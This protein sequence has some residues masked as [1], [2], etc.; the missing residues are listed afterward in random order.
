VEAPQ[1]EGTVPAVDA[2]EALES[3][4]NPGKTLVVGDSLGVGT[5]PYLQERLG[6]VDANVKVGRPSSVGVS[7]LQQKLQGGGYDNVVLDLG[8]NDAGPRELRRSIEQ[9]KRLAGP[10]V[11]IYVP[12]V[13]GPRAREKNRVIKE[14][15]GGN[16]HVVDWASKASGLAADGVHATS[17][18]YRTR[19]QMIAQAI[20]GQRHTSLGRRVASGG[21]ASPQR[22]GLGKVIGVPHAGTH[23]LGDWQSDNAVDISMPDGTILQ[24]MRDGVVEKVKGGYS[25]GASRFDGY[26]VTIRFKDGNRAFYTH[27]SKANV[28][29][30]Q[31]IRAGQA[32]GRSGSAN[33]VPHL[34]LGVEKGDPRKLIR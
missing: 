34:H 12:T 29:A 5:A 22:G 7:V 30:G 31:R 8:T 9:A 27:L 23:T 14:M 6:A 25:G 2:P 13:N 15:A 11:N 17:R 10:G 26:Q 16:V 32:I 1:P 21:K 24:S 3:P 18:G 28:R 4:A 20:G 19:A 33:G